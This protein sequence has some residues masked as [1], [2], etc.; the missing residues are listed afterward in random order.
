MDNKYFKY[1]Y[2]YIYIFIYIYYII[3]I[4]YTQTYIYIHVNLFLGSIP[5][6]ILDRLPHVVLLP[7][8]YQRQ[9]PVKFGF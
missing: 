9:N 3:Y 1:I 2:R 8:F 4:V 6:C 5:M 7:H